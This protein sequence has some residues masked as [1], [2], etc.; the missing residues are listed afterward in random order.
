MK[1]MRM[2]WSDDDIRKFLGQNIKITLYTDLSKYQNLHEL[3]TEEKDCCII[4]YEEKHLSGHWTCL[5]RYDQ[6]F[7]FFD[8]YG[9]RFIS[10]L[11]MLIS[12]LN[13]AVPYLTHPLKGERYDYNK[14]KYQEDNPTIEACGDHVCHFLYCLLKLDMNLAKYKEYMNKLRKEMDQSYDYVVASFIQNVLRLY[15]KWWVSVRL[16]QFPLEVICED[17]KPFFL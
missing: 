4:L 5:T 1:I 15:V 7:T 2:P 12:Q 13:E 16:R 3:L 9:I 17:T 6:L 10:E 8:S 11:K 14:V